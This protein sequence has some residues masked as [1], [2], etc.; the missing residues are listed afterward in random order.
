MFAFIPYPLIYGALAD[1]ACLV[2]EESCSKTGNCWLYDSDKF[3][4]YLHGM[5]M[6]LISIGICFDVVV[7]FLSDRLTNFYGEEDEVNGE[8]RVARWIKEEEEEDVIFTKTRNKE[9]VRDMGSIM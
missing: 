5:S 8:E 1:D 9:G 4:Y 7:F 3:R 6:L 2:W